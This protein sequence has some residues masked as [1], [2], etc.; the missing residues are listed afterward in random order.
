[1][2]SSLSSVACRDL[3]L[4][5][6]SFT[7]NVETKVFQWGHNSGAGSVAPEPAPMEPA[8]LD[9]QDDAALEQLRSFSALTF[10]RACQGITT[11]R[12]VSVRCDRGE[13]AV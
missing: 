11:S 12:V 13:S 8:M 6:M 4:L 7:Y 3:K 9:R 2:F 5:T 10:A 1:M